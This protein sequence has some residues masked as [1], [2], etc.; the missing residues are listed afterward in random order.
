MRILWT[1]EA[2]GDLEEILAYHYLAASP[3]TATAVERRIIGEVE[4]PPPYSE[5]IRKSAR[6]P[7]A[8]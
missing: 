1:D 6:I 4:A 5:R 3:R 2:L 8:R 7:D